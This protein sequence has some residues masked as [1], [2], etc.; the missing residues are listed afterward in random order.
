MQRSEPQGWEYGK[1]SYLGLGGGINRKEWNRYHRCSH[2]GG[3]ELAVVVVVV[4][5][6]V[7]MVVVVIVRMLLFA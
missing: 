3:G 5:A 6:A 2:E 4:V 7:V 1:E